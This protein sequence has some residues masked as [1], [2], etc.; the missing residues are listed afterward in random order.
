MQLNAIPAV[1]FAGD[2]ENK[3]TSYGGQVVV[4]VLTGTLW[5]R[6]ATA[7]YGSAGYV[8]INTNV[9]PGS[10][11]SGDVI[12]PIGVNTIKNGVILKGNSGTPS[13]NAGTRQLIDDATSVSA[14]WDEDGLTIGAG[15]SILGGSWTISAIGTTS[16]LTGYDLSSGGPNNGTNGSGITGYDLSLGGPNSGTDGGGLNLNSLTGNIGSG[17]NNGFLGLGFDNGGQITVS[18]DD[19]YLSGGA[20][21]FLRLNGMQ[22]KITDL[23]TSDPMVVDQIWNS[24]GTLKISA[25]T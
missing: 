15:K 23:P 3:V 20:T 6:P 8:A 16:G 2:P 25:G 19:L 18:G 21:N 10:E 17:E 7:D 9:G 24:L 4:N 12:G 5:A 22:L 14:F 11:L 13:V 1:C